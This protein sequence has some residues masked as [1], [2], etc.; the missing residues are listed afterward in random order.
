MGSKSV[1]GRL[2]LQPSSCRTRPEASSLPKAQPAVWLWSLLG[3]RELTQGFSKPLPCT[4]LILTMESPHCVCQ[5]NKC[6]S[7]YPDG[8]SIHECR[9]WRLQALKL[10]PLPGMLGLCL[11]GFGETLAHPPRWQ[12]QGARHQRHKHGPHWLLGSLC[13]ARCKS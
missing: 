13:V 7:L 10:L 11:Q 1:S 3:A 6:H 2:C 8:V 9:S 5:H 4:V 12:L